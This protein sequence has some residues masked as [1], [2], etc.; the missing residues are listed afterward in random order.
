MTPVS[1]W[2]RPAAVAGSFYPDEPPLLRRVVRTYLDA[3][4]PSPAAKAIVAPHA[5]Y[6][7][8]GPVAAA[9]YAALTPSRG[10][11]RRVLVAGVSHR[12]PVAGA[13]VSSASAFDTPLGPVSIDDE[14]RQAALALPGV[15]VDDDAHAGE[16]SVEVQLPFLV[17][18]LGDVAI[19]PLVTGFAGYRAVAAVLDTLWGGD[20]TRIVVSTDLSHYHA[21]VTAQR[22]DR[23]TAAAVVERRLD[24][25]QPEH[26]CGAGALRALLMVAARREVEVRLLDLRTSADTAGDPS[27]VVGYGAFAAG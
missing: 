2:V 7:Y 4:P 15:D 9:A 10:K 27:R 20:E 19:L 1:P 26:A 17:E 14:A 5:G 18:A 23:Q 12:V 22:I 16:H 13:A 25:I 3:A 21:Q 8:S 11:V 24:A 6:R